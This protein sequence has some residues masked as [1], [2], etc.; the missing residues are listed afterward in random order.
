MSAPARLGGQEAGGRAGLEKMG[1]LEMRGI[2]ACPQ[3]VSQ[4][5]QLVS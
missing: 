4:V 2:S 5:D 3:K 1:G